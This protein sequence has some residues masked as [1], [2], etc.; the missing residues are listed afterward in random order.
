MSHIDE[1]RHTQPIDFAHCDAWALYEAEIIKRDSVRL[2]AAKNYAKR[3]HFAIKNNPQWLTP[4]VTD[5]DARRD[6]W[7]L[8]EAKFIEADPERFESARLSAENLNE[9][10]GEL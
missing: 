2:Q 8:F 3:S 7:T 10:V 1:V 6:A 9:F 5:P 4:P